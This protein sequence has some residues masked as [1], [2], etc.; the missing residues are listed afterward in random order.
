LIAFFIRHIDNKYILL[1]F[2]LL[3]DQLQPAVNDQ[4]KVEP[5]VILP[6]KDLVL[7]KQNEPAHLQDAA[8]RLD[9]EL[10]K[11]WV[12]LL[13]AIQRHVELRVLFWVVV[14]G[15]DVE[16][17]CLVLVGGVLEDFA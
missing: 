10:A 2:L 3:M 16:G 6:I 9:A 11:K 13:Q 5:L 17:L 12:L 14:L 7:R 4:V 1:F 15:A 8:D